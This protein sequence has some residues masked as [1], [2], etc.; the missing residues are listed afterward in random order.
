MKKTISLADGADLTGLWVGHNKHVVRPESEVLI[1]FQAL[2]RVDVF[3]D[4]N[5]F[6]FII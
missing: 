6:I 2:R 3:R 1:V 4:V 5:P